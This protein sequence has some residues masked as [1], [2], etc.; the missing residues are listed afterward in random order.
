MTK[1]PD[2][3]LHLEDINDKNHEWV[4]KHSNRT[5][6][7]FGGG[8]FEARRN[9]IS[10]ILSAKDKLDMG[11]KRGEWIYNFH[12]DGDHPRGLWRRAK[13]ED[14]L[15]NEQAKID[16]DVLLDVG[17]LGKDEGESWVFQGARL[18]Y[19][20]YDRALVTLSPG[21]SDSNVVR[22]FDV[23]KKEFVKGGFEKPQSK[24]SMSWVDRDTVII[25]ADFGEGT[26]TES[27]YP[28]TARLWQRGTKL[29]NA[30]VIIEGEFD[31]V[32]VGASF[33]HTPGHERLTA[34]RATDF[35]TTIMYEVD[36][37]SVRAAGARPASALREILLPR[38]ADVGVVRDWVLVTLRHDWDL[39][40]QTFT[41]GSVLVLPYSAVLAGPSADD[42]QVL[43][44]PTAS[45]S[46]L[47][48][49]ATATGLVITILDNVK[50]RILFAAD[51]HV[52]LAGE[53]NEWQLVDVTPQVA[54]FATVQIMAV[55]PLESPDVWMVI[56]DFLTPSS[57]YYGPVSREEL[58]VRKLRS[59]PERFNAE[60]LEIRQLW[61]ESKDGTNVP[62]F[63]IGPT[64]ALDGK[65]PARALLDGY[66][67]FE[68]SRLPMYIA[69]YGKVWLEKGGVYVVANI[70]G[71]GEFGPRWHQAALKANR[72]KAYEDF[73]AVAKDLQ[74]RNITR[75]EGLA[76]I[77]GSNGG[78]LMGNMYTT[79]PELFGA[80]VCRVPLLDMK[81][82]SH[83]LAGAS[84]IEEY[85]DPDT[86]DWQY[87][88]QYSAYHNVDD[89][90][91]P[92]IL[93]TTSTR[94]DRVHPGHARKFHAMLEE[95]GFETYLYENTE[96]GHA[97]AADIDQ[98]ALMT[99]LIF[100]FLDEKLAR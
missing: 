67:G 15:T 38:S 81:R 86:D 71:G 92:P 75:V 41:A 31:D 3:F 52:D 25:G 69:T 70:R 49:T 4:T 34:Y 78:L 53:V 89:G 20:S 33:D 44:K 59:A 98:Q 35:R 43:Y 87:M 77:G 80:I 61:A 91:H 37:H 82:Y 76:A 99:A 28:R 19:P 51:P 58:H 90:P 85:G 88:E 21:G 57:L 13:V 16:W 55:D 39:D 74:E 7:E 9:A 36:H 54:E 40:G 46:F 24:G 8:R 83:L 47:D 14:Y 5:L 18:L 29:A 2:P 22:E 32:V 66:G 97:G 1:T 17:Q 93:L 50:T 79:Y 12:T 60:G 68:V 72:N 95:M 30:P 94:D 73:A 45:T 56:S 65:Q 63:A 42:V 10:E 23:T 96:G 26:L 100:S 62:Y 84:W 27:G 64:A 6:D 48:V 11:S